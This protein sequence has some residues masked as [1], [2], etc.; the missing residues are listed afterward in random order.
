MTVW[1]VADWQKLPTA[2][3]VSILV[4]AYAHEP[5]LA[6]C[7]DSLAGQDAPFPF[8]IIVAEDRSPDATLAV[9]MAAQA[10]HPH[11][12]R[13]VHAS[14]NRGMNP[15]LRFAI[16]LARA[17]ILALCEGDDWWIDPHRLTRGHALMQRF[18]GA[19]LLFARGLKYRSDEDQAAGWDFGPT[20]RIVSAREVLAGYGWLPPTASLMW[21]R[22]VTED[23]PQWLDDAPFGDAPLWLAGMARGGAIYDPVVGVAYRMA[24]PTSFTARLSA[25]DA[26]ARLAYARRAVETLRR[27][28]AHWGIDPRALRHRIDDQRWGAVR[29]LLALGRP[30]GAFRLASAIHP[31]FWWA[32]ARR[33]WTR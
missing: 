6:Q 29:Q 20:P 13:L 7:L 33:R 4:L 32:A 30:A 10:R 23:W 25:A 9:A 18:A 15:N 1:E 21:R 2:P 16:S 26:E 11:R 24:H 8:E 12:I 27:C 19:D 31:S 17:P 5:Y 3:Q 14:A 22:T 28:G